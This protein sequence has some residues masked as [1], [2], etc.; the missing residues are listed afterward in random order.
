[1][2][3]SFRYSTISDGYKC[4]R[5]YELKHVLGLPDGSDKNADLKFGTALHLGIRDMFEGGN[6]IDVFNIFWNAEEKNGLVYGKL[7]HNVLQDLGNTFLERFERLHLK[8]FKP[9]H[10]EKKLS[11]NLGKYK[12]TGTVD[13]LGEYKGVPSVVDWKSAGYPYEKQKLSINEQMYGYN[14]MS[15]EELGYQAKQHVYVVFVKN[16]KEPRIQVLTKQVTAA[17]MDI[18]LQNVAHMCDELTN[19]TIFPKNRN[20]C[21]YGKT[22]CPFFNHC[23]SDDLGEEE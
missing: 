19:R 8:H 10:I 15:R 3:K 18:M 11:C 16:P 2:T 14:A 7:P 12:L 17:K 20:A 23:Y 6:G 5:Y 22:L 4:L 21:M 1:M 13:F 9:A